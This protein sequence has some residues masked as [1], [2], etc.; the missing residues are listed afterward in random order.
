MAGF[1]GKKEGR[2]VTCDYELLGERSR[3]HAIGTYMKMWHFAVKALDT[4]QARARQHQPCNVK[5]VSQPAKAV[6]PSPQNAT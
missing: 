3:P 2:L 5:R 4:L 6:Q 1:S